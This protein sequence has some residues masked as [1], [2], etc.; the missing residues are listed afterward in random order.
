M[1]EPHHTDLTRQP[2]AQELDR[3]HI[4]YRSHPDLTP[5]K[6]STTADLTDYICRLNK[7]GLQVNTASRHG[8]C[9][10][11]RRSAGWKLTTSSQRANDR[12]VSPT[13]TFA[14]LLLLVKDYSVGYRTRIDFDTTANYKNLVDTISI[15]DPLVFR[16]T[17]GMLQGIEGKWRSVPNTEIS[18]ARCCVPRW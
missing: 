13:T 8:V 17:T 9:C 15:F 18:I 11:R 12:Q 5:T 6:C 4:A 14:W 3:S 2:C 1:H 10:H 7:D 16:K